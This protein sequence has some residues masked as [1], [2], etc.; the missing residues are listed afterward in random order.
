MS[1]PFNFTKISKGRHFTVTGSKILKLLPDTSFDTSFRN[2]VLVSLQLFP[3]VCYY[4]FLSYV[5]W[6]KIASSTARNLHSNWPLHFKF[7]E[8]KKHLTKYLIDWKLKTSGF[9]VFEIKGAKMDKIFNFLKDR[10][11]VMSVP[12]NLI[13]GVFSETDVR[14]LKNIISKFF[15]KHSKSY[16]ILNTKRCLKLNGP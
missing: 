1:F 16:N 9:F 14:L 8:T 3:F 11:S 12:M 7:L 6:N 5:Q 10:F 13:F 2:N 15:L 4:V